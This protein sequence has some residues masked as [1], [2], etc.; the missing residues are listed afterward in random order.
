MK[1]FS[2]PK[3]QNLVIA[4]V[5]FALFVGILV[6]Y[7]YSWS[8]FKEGNDKI[9]T[10]TETIIE[11][12]Q[13][14]VK[15]TTKTTDTVKFESAKTLWDWMGLFL[16]PATLA[17][18]G[19]C[20]QYSQEK[21]KR[22]KE[23]SEKKEADN[24]ADQD[25][26]R[27][28]DQRHESA[29]QDYFSILSGLLVDKR[30]KQLLLNKPENLEE[31][32]KSMNTD[33]SD[34]VDSGIDADA[35]LNIIKARTLSLLRLLQDD[36]PRK[37]SVL[38]FLGDT[39][40]LTNLNL[41][42]SKFPLMN[43]NLQDSN[44]RGVNFKNADLSGA[45]LSSANLSTANLIKATLKG[46]NLSNADL[47]SANLHTADLANANL[48]AANLSAAYLESANLKGAHLISAN[49]QDANLDGAKLALANLRKVNLIGA[50]LIGA[51]L[52]NTN[53]ADADLRMVNLKG[54]DL[55]DAD[56]SNANLEGAYLSNANLTRTKITPEQI[57]ST[58]NWETARYFDKTL[59]DPEV[60][61]KLGLDTGLD[62][63]G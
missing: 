45:D 13:K 29:L 14:G 47:S 8:G 42:L 39:N 24:R 25:R 26:K 34:T 31:E 18:L 3:K 50:T 44:F 7:N 40:L 16:A 12:S 6:L 9:L 4:L 53:L 38:S 11:K 41:D 32:A 59:H 22:S 19:F 58:R 2:W 57:Q 48:S 23:E 17:S 21:T 56:L 36:I 35:V 30:F 52:S 28:I 43:A 60:R 27:V 5:I 63:V 46:I 62:Q 1:R 51:K 54:A 49:L 15:T 10:V 33:F 20:F 37:A 55:V 61:R